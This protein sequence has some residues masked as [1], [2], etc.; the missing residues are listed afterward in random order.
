MGIFNRLQGITSSHIN[1][2]QPVN[3]T[4]LYSTQLVDSHKLLSAL[5]PHCFSSGMGCFVTGTHSLVYQRTY[6]CGILT[7]MTSYCSYSD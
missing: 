1:S 2:L 4:V 3:K 7:A 5:T 6:L